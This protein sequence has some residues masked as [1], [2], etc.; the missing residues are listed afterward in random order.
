MLLRCSMDATRA[1]SRVGAVAVVAMVGV[2]GGC[3]EVATVQKYSSGTG[4]WHFDS[5]DGHLGGLDVYSRVEAGNVLM[6][7]LFLPYYNVSLYIYWGGALWDRSLPKSSNGREG[8]NSHSWRQQRNRAAGR[9]RRRSGSG[10]AGG[11]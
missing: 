8:D 9:R 4:G 11:G 10:V 5:V 3:W 2:C 7:A 1:G 6:H